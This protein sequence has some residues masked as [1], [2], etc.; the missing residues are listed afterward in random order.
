MGKR[1]SFKR[2]DKDYYPTIDPRAVKALLP[3]LPTKFKYAEPCVGGGHM[4]QQLSAYNLEC[5]YQ[6]DISTG[7]DAMNLTAADIGDADLFITNL[8]WSRDIFEKLV[9]HLSDIKPL[10][11]LLDAGWIYT[12]RSSVIVRER[13]TDIIPLPRLRWIEGTTMSGK[14]DCCWLRFDA[15]KQGN[16]N[17]HGR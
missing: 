17:F 14:D 11:T 16:T 3:Y 10:W 2:V 9:V 7:Q 5:T 6:G 4:V 15:N 12:A 1:S 8:P 13:L